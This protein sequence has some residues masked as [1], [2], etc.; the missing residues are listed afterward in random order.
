M[1]SKG[2]LR[3]DDCLLPVAGEVLTCEGAWMVLQLQ[4]LATTHLDLRHRRVCRHARR[5]PRR[6]S[7]ALDLP[8]FVPE[9]HRNPSQ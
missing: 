2:L 9:Q 6:A 4:N 3:T 8:L 1:D 7:L 5:P